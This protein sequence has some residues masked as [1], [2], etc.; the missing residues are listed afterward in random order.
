MGLPPHSALAEA[1]RA[2]GDLPAIRNACVTI[3]ERRYRRAGRAEV[4]TDMWTDLKFAAR[5]LRKS[6]GFAIMATTCIAL[7]LCVTTT[8][9]SAVN[10]I[11]IRPLPYP[12][13]EEL[14]VLYGQN[15][16]RGYHGSNIS[17]PDYVSWRDE[18]RSFASM[19]IWTWTTKTIS[20]GE[21]ERIEGAYVSANLFPTLGVSPL[22]GRNFLAAEDKPGQDKV[23]ILS[24]SLWQRRF[25]G[26]K[27]IIGKTVSIDSRPYTVVGVMPANFNFPQRGHI[28]IPFAADPATEGRHNRGY[29]AAL[30]R[31][32]PG[33]T[34]EQAQTDLATVSA[35]LQR[36][37]P[38]E[39]GGWAAELLSMRDDVTGDLRKPLLVFLVAVGLVLLIACANV[40]NLML[41]RGASRQRE[42]AVRTALGADRGRLVRQ[43]LTESMFIAALGGVIGAAFGVWGVRLLRYAFPNTVPFYFSLSPDPRALAF[44]AVVIVVTGMLFG[45]LPALRATKIDVNNSL[46]DGARTGDGASRV[47]MR[48][49]LVV[50]E[51]ALSVILMV[52]AMLLIR[53][54]RAYTTTDLGF[55]QDGVLTA[56]VTLPFA[57]YPERSKRIAFYNQLHERIASFPGVTVVGSIQGIPFSG[58]DLQAGMSFYGRP[59]ARTNQDVV[60]HFQWVFPSFFKA[61]EIPLV[62]GRMF[63]DADRDSLAPVG[64]INESF[65][66]Q[67]FPNEDPIGKRVKIGGPDSPDPWVTVIG[68]VRDF[69]HYR[70]PQPMGP[71]LY[72]PYVTSATVTQTLTVRTTAVDPYTLVP[73]I[74]SAIRELDAQVAMYDIKTL[75][76]AVNQSLWRQRL[77]GQVLGIFASLALLLAVVG[78]Y[79]VISY[80]VAQRTRELGVR[81]ALGAQRGHLLRMVLGHGARLAASGIVL[82]LLGALALTRTLESLLYGVKPTDAVS[83]LGVP[84]LL[85]AVTL[86]ATFFP[87]HKATRVD[88][89]VAIR[90]E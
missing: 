68:V 47:T 18:N 85:G 38:N 3:D 19:G 56:R 71:A 40:A 16:E 74:R 14:V 62:R 46:R 9:L 70:L 86:A 63:T 5:S 82:G 23:A 22:L 84:A 73:L 69:R 1:E 32:R 24:Y 34:L 36:D 2:F 13:D 48:S 35:R 83:F 72:M 77:Q 64:L 43:L 61:M 20:E 87:A 30:G 21:T 44:S 49:T 7:G 52:G 53:S 55:N 66:K 33:V 4:M 89:L 39:N 51:V 17:Y 42:I 76:E 59:A 54:Y 25:A 80:T 37:F 45:A 90:T 57:K 81:V 67:G 58:W 50:A 15:V 41:A 26:D 12:N 75:D 31:L 60:S 88:P 65:V 8:I 29:A 79:G 6:P 27:S 10:A 11:L 78:I 28:W